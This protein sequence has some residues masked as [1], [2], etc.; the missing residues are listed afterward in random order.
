MV[1]WSR[2]TVTY[3]LI[4]RTFYTTDKISLCSALLPLFFPWQLQLKHQL[5]HEKYTPPSYGV[6]APASHLICI[7]DFQW[8]D[9]KHLVKNKISF[10]N[11]LCLLPKHIWPRQAIKTIEFT[12]QK[13][14]YF[15]FKMYHLLKQEKKK[16]K[17]WDQK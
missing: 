17:H 14:N 8:L 9:K 5:P 3:L 7:L 12:N 2:N 1:F 13:L 10:P 6:I 16:K 11:L 4:Q 15:T